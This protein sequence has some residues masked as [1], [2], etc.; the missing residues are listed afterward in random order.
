MILSKAHKYLAALLLGI[1]ASCS[2]EVSKIDKSLEYTDFIKDDSYSTETVKSV[3]SYTIQIPTAKENTSWTSSNFSLMNTPQNIAANINLSKPSLK[4]YKLYSSS[5]NIPSGKTIVIHQDSIF[6]LSDNILYAYELSSPKNIKWSVPVIKAQDNLAGGGIYA[7]DDYIAVSAGSKELILVN[8]QTGNIIWVYNLTNISRSSPLI[9]KDS[10]F[11]NTIDNSLYCIDLKTG[12]LKWIV[13]EAHEKLGFLGASSPEPFNDTIVMPFSSGKLSAIDVATGQSRWSAS[14]SM[15]IG[16]KSYVNDIDMTPVIKNGTAFLSSRNGILYSINATTGTLEWTNQQA[17]GHSQIWVAGDYIY[18]I[19]NNNQLLAIY[20]VTGAI[21]WIHDLEPQMVKKRENLFF[22][23]TYT[24]FKGPTM[25]DGN[26][27]V[28]SSDGYLVIIDAK[29][30]SQVQQ[31]K[32]SK[33]I[34]SPVLSVDNK[35]YMLN[36]FGILSVMS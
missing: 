14:L 11:I 31:F 25:I 21:K 23:E 17:G 28:V 5:S 12:F 7:L 22:D 36:N 15:G 33:E 6:A 29:S 10:V 26:L 8:A 19:N 35:V 2:T 16:N 18:T 27:Y 30:G 4:T 3:A 13:K 34:Y 9:Y 24:T 32:V 20:K 1:L